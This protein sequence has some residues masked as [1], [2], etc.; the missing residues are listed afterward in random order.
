MPKKEPFANAKILI[1]DDEETSIRLLVKV[2][3]DAGYTNIK[4]T[5][6]PNQ[7]Q[8]LYNKI[9]P[10]LL[11][12][13]LHMPHME[14]F[15]IMERLKEEQKEGDDYLP[16]LVIS[17]ER[18]RVIQF[19]A[20]EAGAK[21]FLVKPYDSIE[22]LLRI[23]NFLEVRMLHKQIRDQ[24]KL[25]EERVRERTEQFYQAQTDVIQRLSRAVEYRDSETGT[26][27][28]R[29]GQYAYYLS[30]ALGFG[31][32]ECE[33]ISTASALHDVGKIGIPDSILQK[34]G[35]LTPEEWEIMKTHTTIGVELLSGSTSKFLK[36]GEEIALTHHEKW[37]GTGY[38][39]GLKGGDIP[40]LG[41]ICGLCD[42]FDALTSARPYKDAWS[43][44]DALKEIEKQKGSHFD[45]HVVDCFFTIL[46]QIRRIHEQYGEH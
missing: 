4:A 37:D 42:V 1:V 39:R 2:L 22:V 40:L 7:V 12:L 46:P 3:T 43:I 9:Q 11:V 32:E 5:R 33:M 23:R 34:P 41:R 10:D 24:N 14:G 45:P 36:M 28:A 18:N 27:T 29:M 13:D 8:A 21:D 35:K 38:P 16:I 17:Q 19:S 26:H 31:P 25:L 20:L 44:E 30:T 6:D 15:K